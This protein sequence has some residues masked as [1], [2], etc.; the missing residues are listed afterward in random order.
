M[1]YSVF[2]QRQ[3]DAE[4]ALR[5]DARLRQFKRGQ[6]CKNKQPLCRSDGGCLRCDADA[7]ETCRAEKLAVPR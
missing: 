1:R 4:H 3:M 6:P 5:E 7:G 2:Q